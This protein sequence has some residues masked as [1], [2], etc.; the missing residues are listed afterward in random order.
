MSK[1]KYYLTTPIYYVNAAPH[2]GT[3]YCTFSTDLIKRH[4]K[5]QGYHPVVLTTGSDEHGQKVERAA[6]A[7]GKTPEEYATTIANE[8]VRQWQTLGISYDHFIR[9]SDLKHFAVV[10]DLF[11]RC[12][13]NGY[14]YTGSY[15][16]Q[17]C[18]FDELYV[19]GAKPGDPQP[20]CLQPF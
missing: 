10:R 1:G 7:A 9:T 12:E 20:E 2:I 13:K 18:F 16:G 11:E 19:I 3:A 8:F 5:Q 14:I 17:Y 4:K 15:T 6:K